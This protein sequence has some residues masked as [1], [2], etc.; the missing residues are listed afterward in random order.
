MQ[1]HQE[2]TNGAMAHAM[3]LKQLKSHIRTLITLDE[4]EAPMVSCYVQRD[5]GRN[6]SILSFERRDRAIRTVLRGQEL[7]EFEQAFERI[8]GQQLLDAVLRFWQEELS[9]IDQQI[10]RLR[11]QEP[12]VAYAQIVSQLG[13]GWTATAAR[14]RFG[15]AMKQTRAFLHAHGWI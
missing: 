3:E 5:P 9:P 13:E 15:R 6:G 8:T 4:T 14:Q 10:V 2:S 12:P 11:L 7:L 1:I